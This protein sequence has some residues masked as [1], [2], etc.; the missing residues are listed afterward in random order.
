MKID[1]A[2]PR[3]QRQTASVTGSWGTLIVDP[4][5][6]HVFR[7]ENEPTEYEAG[8]TGYRDIV[9]I[10]IA[11]WLKAYPNESEFKGADILDVG[12]WFRDGT[13]EAPELEWRKEY[14]KGIAR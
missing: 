4:F 3:T 13:Y 9:R 5:D 11:E 10:D 12:H 14:R 6:G 7:L 1:H 8:E 2:T